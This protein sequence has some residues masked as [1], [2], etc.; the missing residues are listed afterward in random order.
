MMGVL[1]T[2]VIER[3]ILPSEVE[4]RSAGENKFLVVGYAYKFGSRSQDLGGFK[5]QILEGAGAE[6]A[7]KD[8]I[9]ALVN[10]DANLILGRN[11]AE[12]LKLAE[13][14]TGLHYEIQVDERQSYVR[15]LLISL[16]RGDVSQS[17]FGFSVNPKGEDW[18]RDEDGTP[19]RSIRSMS[20][21]DVSPVTY[22]AYLASE[23]KVSKRALDY[24]ASLVTDTRTV[25]PVILPD[26]LGESLAYRARML[27]LRG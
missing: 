11:R 12:T 4:A 25:M 24:A 8:D 10:H 23:S 22:P 16:E 26:V 13:D 2:L 3:R 1:V 15:D 5:E 18:T 20:L 6:S 9:R 21:F 17:S 19:L 27:S 7:S 14:S